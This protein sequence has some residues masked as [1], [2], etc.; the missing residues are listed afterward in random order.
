MSAVSSKRQLGRS[1]LAVIAGMAVGIAVTLATDIVL[2]KMGVLPP[3][4]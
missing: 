3:L 4:G 1:V 2:R